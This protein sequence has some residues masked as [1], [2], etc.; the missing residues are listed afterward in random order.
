MSNGEPTRSGVPS[1]LASILQVW[2]LIVL[3][4]GGIWAVGQYQSQLAYFDRTQTAQAQRQAQF[5]ANLFG[6][7][8][9][10]D[11]AIQQREE[12]IH[13]IERAISVFEEKMN[14]NATNLNSIRELAQANRAAMERE[15]TTILQ[16]LSGVR[17]PRM[18]AE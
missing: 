7:L 18:S 1:W 8:Q 4:G 14:N 13:Q 3:V 15:H 5:E 9:S 16:H 12:R 10:L 6:R 11:A 17:H 2:P